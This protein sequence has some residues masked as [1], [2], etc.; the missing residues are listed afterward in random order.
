MKT[1]TTYLAALLLAGS[2]MGCAPI[3]A[4]SAQANAGEQPGVISKTVLT[5][6][7]YCHLKFPAIDESTLGTKHPTLK[8]PDSGDIIDYYGSCDENP[9]GPDQVWHQEL[10]ELHHWFQE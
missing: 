5:P 7:S 10:D 4:E 3:A 2:L 8:S 1:K 6:G 9:L